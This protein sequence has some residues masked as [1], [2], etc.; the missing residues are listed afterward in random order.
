MANAKNKVVK[1]KPAKP[2]YH[3][4]VMGFSSLKKANAFY[5][6]VAKEQLRLQDYGV[7]VLSQKIGGK[8]PV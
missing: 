1:K 5:N 7:R 4:I 2:K 3:V 6:S 8:I